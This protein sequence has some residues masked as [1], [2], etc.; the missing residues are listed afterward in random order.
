MTG[1]GRGAAREVLRL[2]RSEAVPRLPRPRLWAAAA[3]T[4]VLVYWTVGVAELGSPSVTRGLYVVLLVVPFALVLARV[5]ATRLHRAEWIAMAVGLGLWTAGTVAQVTLELRGPASSLPSVLAP[6]WLSMYPLA[7]FAF[8]SVARQ[9]LRRLPL[10]VVLDAVIV[11]L[12][13]AALAMLAVVPAVVENASELTLGRQVLHLAYPVADTALLAIALSLAVLTGLPA[14][15][16]WA[17]LGAGAVALLVADVTWALNA[18]SGEP[19]LHGFVPDALYPL[20]P[21]S[22]AAVAWM[23]GSRRSKGVGEGSVRLLGTTLV[24]ALTALGLLVL[25]EWYDV[26]APAVVLAAAGLLAAIHRTALALTASVRKVR[27]DLRALGTVEEVG[28]ALERGRLALHFQPLVD[29]R[30]GAVHGAE[31]LLRWPRGDGFV[32]P[33]EYLPAVERSPLMRPLTD[34]VVDTA[35]EQLSVWRAAGNPIGVS[36]N[37]AAP[38]LAEDDLAERVGRALDRHGLPAR[39]LTL[40]ITETAAIEDADAA[41]AV[42]AALD[43]LGVE[44]SIDDFGSGHSSLE[45]LARFPLN[46]VKID[47]SFVMAMQTAD[48]PIVA[49]TI[50]LAHTLGLRVVAEGVEDAATLNALDGMACDLAQGYLISRPLPPAAFLEWIDARAR[51]PSTHRDAVGAILSSLVLELGMDAAFISRFVDDRKV[52]HAFEGPDTFGPI[53]EGAALPRASSYCDRVARGV[54]PNIIPHARRDSRTAALAITRSANLGAYVGVALHDAAGRLY[55]SLCCISH[56]ERPGLAEHEL[57]VVSEVATRLRPL[58][59]DA[60]LAIARARRSA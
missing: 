42:L 25:N 31:A 15:R 3:A 57:Q 1:R 48:R 46:E 12:I 45:R 8:A 30:T 44:L 17:T 18:A 26:P 27:D 11:A 51:E 56:D 9:R 55:G 13:L 20:W 40:E 28:S 34:F 47:R 53:K 23:P 60:N 29:V 24:A 2:S 37:L 4:T 36:V 43:R 32:P 54:F 38:N 39:A 14:G 49:T 35:L 10:S 52:I 16:L 21:L 41:D 7:L 58:L 33:D 6:L 22:V 50:Q 19:W 5:L 59:A